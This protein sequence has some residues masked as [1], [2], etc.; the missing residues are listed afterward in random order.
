VRL[1]WPN[2]LYCEGGKLAG[3][4]IEARWREQRLDWVAIGMGINVRLP[5]EM[6]GAAA[7]RAVDSRANV[8]AELVPALRAA[9]AARG[10]L[11]ERELMAYAERDLARGS[12]LVR[13][14]AGDVA[15]RA[16][17]LVFGE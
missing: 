11:S 7:L 3:I 2:D 4:L 16:G 5:E 1:K 17:S 14:P 15:C 8:L 10:P 12:L 9:A 6:P 13:T